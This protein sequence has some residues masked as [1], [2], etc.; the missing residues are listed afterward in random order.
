MP[1]TRGLDLSRRFYVDTVRPVL[2]ARFPGLPHTAAR[3]G[4]GSEVQGFDTE[5]S[6]DHDWGPRLL[7]FVQEPRPDLAALFDTTPF[8]GQVV[9]IDAWFTGYLGF[10][11]RE[12]VSTADWLA[13]PTQ[14]LAEVTA[15]A[16]FH[17]DLGLSAA[18]TRLAWYPD[19]V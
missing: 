16:V 1:F 10:D 9:P 7:L 5:R 4:P 11:P 13:T 19:D 6:T 14:T 18:R 15:G 17:D 12:D 2:D 8:W 3:I